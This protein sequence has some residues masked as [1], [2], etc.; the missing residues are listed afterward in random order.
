MITQLNINET[1]QKIFDSYPDIE[2]EP[3]VRKLIN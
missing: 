1:Y 3:L 2:L